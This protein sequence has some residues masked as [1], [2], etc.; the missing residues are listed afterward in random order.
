MAYF[1]CSSQQIGPGL[2]TGPDGVER[3]ME[4]H[5]RCAAAAAV[6]YGVHSPSKPR[7]YPSYIYLLA[8]SAHNATVV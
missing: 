4:I 1:F 7:K 5:L 3:E 6:R 8:R 2:G